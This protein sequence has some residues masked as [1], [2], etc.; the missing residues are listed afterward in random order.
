[1]YNGKVRILISAE[2]HNNMIDA[3]LKNDPTSY[4]YCPDCCCDQATLE[5]CSTK[6][7]FSWLL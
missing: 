4:C 3:F 6:Q 2:A 5:F 7:P 1:M